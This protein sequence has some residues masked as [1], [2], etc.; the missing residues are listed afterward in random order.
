MKGRHRRARAVSM[1]VRLRIVRTLAVALAL[2]TMLS[3][4]K[5]D[6]AGRSDDI[7]ARLEKLRAVPYTSVTSEE[8]SPDTVG[9]MF[10]DRDR[11]W[12]GYNL[13]CSRIEPEAFLIDMEGNVVNR[14]YY[15]QDR[16][17]FWN[18]ALLLENG[19]I[20]VL[21]KFW[22]VFM[23]DWN[24]NLVRRKM[25]QG[26]ISHIKTSSAIAITIDIMFRSENAFSK[27]F[28]YF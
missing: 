11:A 15:K 25:G 28:R 8:V 21:N 5:D 10:Y 12:K 26:R 9:V 23:L 1:H 17:K 24:S 4:G 16:L 18:Y 14:W 27:V 19:N 7:A 2:G 3:C 22:Y 20:I 13:Y 6:A